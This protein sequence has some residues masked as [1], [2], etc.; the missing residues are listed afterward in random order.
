MNLNQIAAI[1]RKVVATQN[2][3]SAQ[4]KLLLAAD[5]GP[6]SIT[7]ELDALPGRRIFYNLTGNQDFDISQN[8]TRAIAISFEVSQDGPFVLTHYP[9]VTWRP[10]APTNADNFG[11]WSPVCSWPVPLQQKS[12]QDSIDLSWEF[13]DGG[14]QRAFTNEKAAPLF[15]RPDNL[16]PLPVPTLLAPNANTQFIP[17]YEDIF[18]DPDPANPTTGGNLVVTLPG[19]RVVNL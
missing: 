11:Q 18:F 17:T 6:Q 10:N 15:S 16:V 13:F 1:V 5:D 2:E 7:E 4:F 9:L 12:N 8:G 3:L 14:S 19:Y